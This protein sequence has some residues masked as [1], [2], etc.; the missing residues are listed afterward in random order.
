MIGNRIHLVGT[1]YAGTDWNQHRPVRWVVN[2]ANFADS[3]IQD[4]TPLIAPDPSWTHIYQ[5][6]DINAAGEIV[7]WGMQ[8]YNWRSYILSGVN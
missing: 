8:N 2:P 6:K 4:L 5:V 3:T 7:G 1:A